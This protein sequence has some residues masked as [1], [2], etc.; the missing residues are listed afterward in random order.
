[1]AARRNRDSDDDGGLDSLLDTMTNVVGILVLVLVVTQLSVKDVVTQVIAQS[2]VEA[3]DLEE[4]KQQ[5]VEKKEMADEL[6]RILVSPLEIDSEKQK[7]ELQKKK[8][9]LERQRKLMEQKRQ[10]KNQFALKMKDDRELAKQNMQLIED[11][12]EKR[13]ELETLVTKSL[14]EK[15]RLDALLSKMPRRAAPADIKVSIPNPRPPPPGAKQIPMVCSQNLVYPLNIEVFRSRADVRAKEI[16]ARARLVNDPIKGIDPEKFSQFWNQLKDQDDYFDV[17]YYVVGDRHLRLRFTPREGR[18]G[19]D[20]QLVNPRS[21]IRVDYLNRIDPTQYYARF[22]VLPDSY[23]V[24]V[25]ARR[26]F[27]KSGVLT[28]WD[29]QNDNY[30]Y[31][32]WVP[33]GIELGPPVEKED[34]PPPKPQNLI[35]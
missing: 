28:G 31:T 23:D 22:Y 3:E 15:A 10:E 11:T 27:D 34:R 12:K 8:E 32:S 4:V 33:G 24:Y 19:T 21:K 17:E 14:D 29:P 30:L 18:G 13:A 6:E 5:L 35:D 9:L 7:E 16:I 25:T 20:R 2:K 26:L 1:M